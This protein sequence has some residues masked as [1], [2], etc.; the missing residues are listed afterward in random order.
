M[1]GWTQRVQPPTSAFPEAQLAQGQGPQDRI[2]H[3]LPWGCEPSSQD[4]ELSPQ[5]SLEH[6]L[7]S[8]ATSWAEEEIGAE[9][10]PGVPVPVC[11]ESRGTSWRLTQP[12]VVQV[13]FPLYDPPAYSADHKDMAVQDP[14]SL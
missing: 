4:P 3:C 10:V 5:Q 11:C 13:D 8:D 7:G 2:R 1:L 6:H 14:F 9:G 12:C